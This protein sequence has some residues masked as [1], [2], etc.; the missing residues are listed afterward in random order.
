MLYP[1]YTAGLSN[2]VV[3]LAGN[4]VTALATVALVCW[5]W[6]LN[7]QAALLVLPVAPWLAFASWTILRVRPA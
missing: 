2:P 4:I 6:P 1:L 5:L 7:R 3:G